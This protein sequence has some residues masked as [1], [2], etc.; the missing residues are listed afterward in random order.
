MTEAILENGPEGQLREWGD[1]NWRCTNKIV[2]NLRGR[3]FRARKLGLWK[4]LLRLQKLMKRCHANLLLSIKQITQVNTGKFT[5]GVD[6]EVIE[7]PAQR[8]TLLNSWR[9]PE[10]KPA[11]RVYIPKANG[12]KRPLGIPLRSNRPWRPVRDRVAQAIVK[13][14]LEP[15]WEAM[16]ESNSYGFRPGR[17]CH[18]A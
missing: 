14:A 7:T 9:M 2:R 4:Q 18:D 10:A 3:I 16:F 12:K 8:S 17:S 6:K 15:E 13:N 5:A 11:R 1:I